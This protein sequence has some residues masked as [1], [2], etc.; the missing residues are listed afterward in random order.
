MS[1]KSCAVAILALALAACGQ[2]KSGPARTVNRPPAFHPELFPDIKLPPAFVLQPGHDQLAVVYAGGNIR[3]FEVFMIQKEGSKDQKPAEVLDLYRKWLPEA[4][5]KA[6]ASDGRE[7]RWRKVDDR[8]LGDE[9]VVRSGR[10]SSRTTIQFQ[11]R[12]VGIHGSS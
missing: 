1:W 2:A 10:T 8:G 5:W 3:R 11:L 9:L 4:G 12:P 6:V 7:Q